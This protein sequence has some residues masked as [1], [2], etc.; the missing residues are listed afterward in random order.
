MSDKIDVDTYDKDFSP[1]VAL[2]KDLTNAIDTI[3]AYE[4]SSTDETSDRLIDAI[5]HG[6][7]TDELRGMTVANLKRLAEGTSIL[8]S[9]DNMY[10]LAVNVMECS[11]SDSDHWHKFLYSNIQGLANDNNT[12]ISVISSTPDDAVVVSV[13][14]IACDEDTSIDLNELLNTTLMQLQT[15][16]RDKVIEPAAITGLNGET[17]S[18][19]IICSD[20]LQGMTYGELDEFIRCTDVATDHVVSTE[21]VDAWCDGVSFAS[22]VKWQIFLAKTIG[23]GIQVPYY[24]D[25]T[26][27][28][29]ILGI[30]LDD[31]YL[32]VKV[33]D[34]VVDKAFADNIKFNILKQLSN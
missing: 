33:R 8:L 4:P 5:P 30:S 28:V 25:A 14:Y 32:D 18:G 1:V 2:V 34:A 13:S 24:I 7:I 10:G 19:K 23:K 26:D 17:Y 29:G 11:P 6:L 27:T 21:V 31:T 15:T 22:F 12:S 16:D 3:K 9:Y 20:I